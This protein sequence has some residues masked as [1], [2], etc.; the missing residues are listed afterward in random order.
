ML[1]VALEHRFLNFAFAVQTQIRQLPIS[2]SYRNL[3]SEL[4]HGSG[5]C[6]SGGGI[7]AISAKPGQP[8]SPSQKLEEQ[9]AL[10]LP[11]AARQTA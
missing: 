11:S 4:G 2:P 1:Q 10:L 9:I 3:G 6:H 5:E 7:D 8:S